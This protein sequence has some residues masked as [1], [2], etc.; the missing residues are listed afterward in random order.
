[1]LAANSM[2]SLRSRRK[3]GLAPTT[4]ACAAAATRQSPRTRARS[5]GLGRSRRRGPARA[6]WRPHASRQP[7]LRASA[8]RVEPQQR[9]ARSAGNARLQQ[10][11]PLVCQR[12]PGCDHNSCDVAHRS[13]Q[14][15]ARS[16]P[17]LG[18]RCSER[19]WGSSWSHPWP[20]TPQMWRP[21]RSHPPEGPPIRERAQADG[22]LAMRIALFHGQVPTFDI[23]QV[24]HRRGEKGRR[25]EAPSDTL[26]RRD[27]AARGDECGRQAVRP[28]GSASPNRQQLTP[29]L[30]IA[31]ALDHL[32]YA[33]RRRWADRVRYF[34]D[35]PFQRLAA[36]SVL[37]HAHWS[38]LHRNP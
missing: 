37:P 35:P 6:Q 15:S 17:P 1:M 11:H 33:Q 13:S 20:P 5:H 32:A 8:G 38:T 29:Q 23:A 12:A 26:A 25:F 24:A 14:D 36:H 7:A 21:Q 19:R 28:T 27:E 3:A 2:I 31:A 4:R 10:F 18:R 30:A 9:D 22:R 34:L 16:P